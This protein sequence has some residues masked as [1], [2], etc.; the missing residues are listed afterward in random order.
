MIHLGLIPAIIS[1]LTILLMLA[2][3]VVL[4][5]KIWGCLQ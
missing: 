4:G 3:L 2:G 1:G 5:R